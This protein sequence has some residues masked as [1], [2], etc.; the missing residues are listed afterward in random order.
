VC[1]VNKAAGQINFDFDEQGRLLGIEVL[2]ASRGLPKEVLKEAQ[3]I[4]SAVET[5]R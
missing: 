1:D 4:D 2:S 5:R 3:L